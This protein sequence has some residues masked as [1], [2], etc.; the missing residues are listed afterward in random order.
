[1]PRSRSFTRVSVAFALLALRVSRAPLTTSGT[2]SP[3]LP[4]CQPPAI[5]HCFTLLRLSVRLPLRP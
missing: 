5:A 3:A 1:L 4:L 2:E